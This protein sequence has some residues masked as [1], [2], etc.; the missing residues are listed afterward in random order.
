MRLEEKLENKQYCVNAAQWISQL[1]HSDKKDWKDEKR[2]RN[3]DQIFHTRLSAD[4]KELFRKME[5]LETKILRASSQSSS[6]LCKKVYQRWKTPKEDRR[7]WCRG[8]YD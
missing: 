2:S 7:E 6:G 1:R 5:T 8:N 3:C 4:K